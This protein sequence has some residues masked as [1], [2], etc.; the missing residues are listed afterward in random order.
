MYTSNFFHSK[1]HFANIVCISQWYYIRSFYN[2]SWYTTDHFILTKVQKM[3]CRIYY[4][5]LQTRT[6]FEPGTSSNILLLNILLLDE[7]T[8][9][10]KMQYSNTPRYTTS[11]YT[12][13]AGARFEKGFKN[14][15]DK[16]FWDMNLM[17]HDFKK[18]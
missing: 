3:C 15:R 8:L 16:R 18:C 1:I 10:Y 13:L 9:N 7:G 17:G 12:N 11:R 14:F 5:L 4:D 6:G 2:R